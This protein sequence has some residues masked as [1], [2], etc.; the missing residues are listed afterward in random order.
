MAQWI[1]V[2]I[3]KAEDLISNPEIPMKGNSCRLSSDL[4][5]QTTA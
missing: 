5:T 1:K 3:T 2:I 4:H